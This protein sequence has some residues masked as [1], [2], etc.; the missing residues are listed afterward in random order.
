MI[1]SEMSRISLWSVWCGRKF[2][3]SESSPILNTSPPSKNI[4][5]YDDIYS[6]K[7]VKVL[8]VVEPVYVHITIKITNDLPVEIIFYIKLPDLIYPD[9]VN[10]RSPETSQPEVKT[11]SIYNITCSIKY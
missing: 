11:F 7:K 9:V 1:D 5:I 4:L 2:I 8:V 10:G 3:P 6:G